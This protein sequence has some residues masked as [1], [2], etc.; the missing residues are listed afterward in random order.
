MQ[1]DIAKR[2]IEQFSM[3]GD[4]VFDPFVGIGTV[5]MHA[6]KMGRKGLG[7][8]L[9]E[10]YFADALRYMKAAEVGMNTPTL[11]NLLSEDQDAEDSGSVEVEMEL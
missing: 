9:S 8:E 7:V 3:P 5:A 6:V 11:F 2:V 1:E 4:T 10:V